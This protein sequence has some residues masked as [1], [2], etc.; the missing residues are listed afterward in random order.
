MPT[1]QEQ[2]LNPSDEFTPIPFWFWNDT[3]T[4]EEIISQIHD[5]YEKGVMG[6]VLHPR[7]G[8]P[9]DMVYLSDEF[10]T[11]VYAA[12]NEASRL[13][14][15]VILYDEAMY[16][17]GSAQGRVVKDNPEYASR[18]LGVV[19]YAC[20]GKTTIPL[21]LSPD[22]RLVSIQAVKKASDASICIDSI[23]LLDQTGDYIEFTPP[24]VGTWVILV[25]TETFSKGTIR[26]IHFGED[27][28]EAHAPASTDLL[29]PDAVAKFIRLTHDTYYDTLKEFFGQTVIA[30][31]TDEPDIL[32]RNAVPG[33][34]PWTT[35]FLDYYT[36]HGHDEKD[37]PVLWY[38]AGSRTADIRKNYRQTVIRRLT[39]SYYK[40][41]SDWCAA[42]D[43]ALTGHPEDSDDIGL[44]DYFQIPGQDVVWRWVAPED[45]KALEGEHSTAGKCS[46]DAARHRGRR[47]NLN[48]FLGVCSKD[49]AWSL[50]PGDMKW[51]MDWLL[52]RGV[53]LMCPHAFYYSIDGDRRSQ[54][55]PPDVGPNNHWWP[56]YKQFAQY[57]KRLSWLMTD[58]TNIT[59][60]A[61]L[62]EADH[63]PWK[64]TKPLFENQVEFNYLEESLFLN[65]AVVENGF[66]KIADQA[67]GVIVIEDTRKLSQ[68]VIRKLETFIQS[69]G[70]VIAC[71]REQSETTRIKNAITIATESKV[72]GALPNQAKQ[73]V[74]LVPSGPQVRVTKVKKRDAIFYF[75]VNEGE[76]LYDGAFFVE[77]L[78]KLEKW[79]P[80][81]ATI[82]SL[83]VK[84]SGGSRKVPL[85]LNR[86]ESIVYCVHLNENQS[87][88][89]LSPRQTERRTITI[90]D[91][92]LITNDDLQLRKHAELSVWNEWEN[93]AHFSGTLTYENTF[94][95]T[96]ECGVQ[97]VYI[98]LGDV[99]E[100]AH[101]FINNKEVGVKMWAPYHLEIDPAALKQG[102][103]HIKIHVSNTVANHMDKKSFAS[104]LLGPVTIESISEV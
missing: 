94:E 60:V 101:V 84:Q 47:R 64:I 43:I 66:L 91:T 59:T 57:M 27:D 92:W 28:G 14:M 16:P 30:M 71:E 46:A 83:P 50:S 19:E 62:C 22:E 18:G 98:N 90:D 100:I 67:Y 75:F 65:P 25:F 82:E 95:W 36:Q 24:E 44:L 21:D 103:N 63:L 87:L 26:G 9:K 17:S 52:V 78:G 12:V 81:D 56:F 29:N 3:L 61:V 72:V 93:M 31:F 97:N 55:R 20:N 85:K 104:G 86:R 96:G 37:L 79:N 5:F 68:D 7:I 35:H 70:D 23:T 32:G 76:A 45:G 8:I 88:R 102:T 38:D 2:F 41:I 40:Q 4:E 77:E 42:H 80:W 53:N 13:G 49:S 51:Y 48:E 74:Q 58:S 33:L 1:L 39:E 10:M 69:G 73:E 99:Y 6:F 15:S 89:E 34:K 11:L 54:E